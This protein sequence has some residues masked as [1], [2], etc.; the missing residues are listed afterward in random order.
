M[1]SADNVINSYMDFFRNHGILKKK[2]ELDDLIDKYNIYDV[3]DTEN[4][5]NIN[6]DNGN[7]E[8]INQIIND[9]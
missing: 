7:I 4:L 1:N 8:N 2:N 3:D 5:I 6:K 9:I